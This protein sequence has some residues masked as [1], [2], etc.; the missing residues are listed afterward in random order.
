MAVVM[1]STRFCPFCIRARRVFEAKGVAFT[2]IAVDRDMAKRRKMESL[3][4][5]NTVPQIWVGDR[6]VGGFDDLWLL[7]QR[8]ELDSLLAAP[9]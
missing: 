7:E 8:G 1:Y 6:H 5:R 2:D 4:G 3:S 9:K